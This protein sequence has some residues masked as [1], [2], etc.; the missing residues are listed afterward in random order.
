MP[1]PHVGRPHTAARTLV[2]G[3]RWGRGSRV[4]PG[5]LAVGK[6]R[7]GLA[8]R[9]RSNMPCRLSRHD[10][11]MTQPRDV[12]TGSP[13]RQPIGL[14]LPTDIRKREGFAMKTRPTGVIPPMTTP[15]RKD[16][17]IDFKLVA[18]QVD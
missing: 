12:A 14:R 7:G 8:P 6:P 4:V 15:F 10:S 1:S 17:E 9:E 3:G 18:P 2:G 11:R 5:S 16:G 13:R